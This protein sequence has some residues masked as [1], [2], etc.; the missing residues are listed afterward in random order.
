MDKFLAKIKELDESTLEFS[1]YLSTSNP[2]VSEIAGMAD[3][4]LID[5]E[6]HCNWTNI[7]TMKD[8]KYDVFPIERDR[9]GWVIGGIQT[10]KGIIA[11]G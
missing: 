9:F 3:T 10:S 11:Y 6:G 7:E 2:L 4:F 1:D 5:N 8:N